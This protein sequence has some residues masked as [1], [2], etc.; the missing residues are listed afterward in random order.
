MRSKINFPVGQQK[1]L[2]TVKR[3]KLA[4]FEHVT[5]HENLSKIILQGTL[6]GG[7]RRG[8]EKIC[9][10]ENVKEWTLLL[11]P[12]L[13]TRAFYRKDWKKFSA[14]SSLM[15]APRSRPVKGL[16]KTDIDGD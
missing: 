4:W 2:A 12:D 6:E 8:R 9:W 10:T 15:P 7:R 16:T 5:C 14:E 1:L 3:L 13:L 11:M